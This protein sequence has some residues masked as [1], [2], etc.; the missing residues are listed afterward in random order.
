M[1][2]ELICSH[3]E[4]SIERYTA[5]M[6]PSVVSTPSA[7]DMTAVNVTVDVQVKS[8][9]LSIRAAENLKVK[10]HVNSLYASVSGPTKS[11]SFG[12]RISP[13]TVGAYTLLHDNETGSTSK[14]QLPSIRIHGRQIMRGDE[15]SRIANVQLG[16]FKGDIKPATLDRL[17]Q[18][19]SQLSKVYGALRHQYGPGVSKAIEA[20]RLK[21]GSFRISRSGSSPASGSHS[22]L[23][24]PTGL[25]AP[26]S[27]HLPETVIEDDLPDTPPRSVPELPTP[28]P[29]KPI[30]WDVRASVRRVLIGFHADNVASTIWLQGSGLEGQYTTTESSCNPIWGAKANHLE[31]FLGY[32]RA[33]IGVRGSSAMEH[34]SASMSLDATV[35]ETPATPGQLCRLD[36]QLHRVH[37][38]MHAVALRELS[39]LV[40]SWSRDVRALHDSRPDEMADVKDQTSK[41]I[42]RFE[43]RETDSSISKWLSER[44]L[45]FSISGIGIA[46]PLD[47]DATI[48][49]W[50]RKDTAGS[51]LLFTIHRMTFEN[52]RNRAATFRLLEM[53]L[54]FVDE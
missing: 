9:A 19:Y 33:D 25:L 10:W 17:L 39:E 21:S 51:A 36:I 26:S 11:R 2:R 29:G 22:A 52:Q 13:Q 40:R 8:A 5:R 42:K 54:Q 45:V 15:E 49:Q 48:D 35:Q 1:G 38:V 41:F 7:S 23:P 4:P 32:Q 46:V 27:K 28:T 47:A 30:A 31:V 53:K 34:K 6:A 20:A 37:S 43:A 50:Q 16:V 3:Y 44:I 12:I 24:R 18:L 14:L